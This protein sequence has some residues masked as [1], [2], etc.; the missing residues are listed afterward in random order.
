MRHLRFLLP[1]ILAASV[2][3]A[4]EGTF[5]AGAIHPKALSKLTFGPDGILFVADSISA[6]IFAL[7]LDD[8]KPLGKPVKIQINDV[9]GKIAGLLGADP[10]DVLI[11]DMAV[12]P[13]SK[14][15]YLT[16][17]RGRRNFVGLWQLPND[18]A[19]ASVLLRI[20]P[21]G[22][23]Q[24]VH[25]DKVKHSVVDLTNP[26]AA[27]VMDNEIHTLKRVDAI[28]DM[29]FADGKL[30]VAGLSNEE[31]S[32]TLRIYPYPF[33]GHSSA[34]ALEI[35][36]GSHGRYETDSP[37]R[38]LLPISIQGKPYILASYLCTPLVLFPFEALQNAKQV[39]GQTIAE[40]GSGNYPLDM[41]SFASKDKTY[42]MVVNS[43]QGVV[44]IDS[45]ELAKPL[46]S[47]TQQIR[48]R[49]GI[50]SRYLRNW[51]LLQVENLDDRNLLVLRR[52]SL[53]GEVA[54]WTMPVEDID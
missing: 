49:A 27:A 50:P 7:D 2:F 32:S 54:L 40:F 20:T 8:R 43:T 28:S 29:K 3:A 24:E 16:V 47:I 15:T 30:I 23:I 13:I 39:K 12:N 11:H 9:E 21:A 1:A 18:V 53:N 6:R 4:S 37:I 36:H 34:S 31:F 17:S 44:L 19:N 22:D 41:V 46:P 10:R 5:T 52:N 51:G 42:I 48:D 35:Y 33:D 25:L 45:A 38:T 26:V 14:N